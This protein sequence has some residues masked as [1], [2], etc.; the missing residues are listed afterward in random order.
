MAKN[1]ENEIYLLAYLLNTIIVAYFLKKPTE[2]NQFY[3]VKY[4]KQTSCC[5]NPAISLLPQKTTII[6][7][8]YGRSELT[9]H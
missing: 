1:F 7:S 2:L 8:C 9:W 5:T 3:P 6:N 4:R